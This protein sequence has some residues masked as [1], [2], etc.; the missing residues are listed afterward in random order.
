MNKFAAS[1]GL[2]AL[3]TTALHAVEATALNTMQQSKPW[4]VAAS[5]RGFYDDNINTSQV[6]V[7]SFGIEISPSVDFGLAGEQ[8]SFNL[9]YQLSARWYDTAPFGGED[10]WD[11]THIFD[12]ALTHTFSP[13]VDM[14]IQNSF[15]IGQEPDILRDS[16][17]NQRIDGNNL[18]NFGSI[19]FNIEVTELMGL[20]VGYRNSYFNY[21][22]PSNAALL[23]R[24]ENRFTIDSRW[25]LQPK[26][27]GIV[28]YTYGQTLYTGDAPIGVGIM[29]D[30]R[31]VRSH[32]MYVGA[33][34]SFTPTLSGVLKAGAE[35]LDYYGNPNGDNQWSPYVEGTVRY[36]YRST[37]SMD[38]GF[39]YSHSAAD[40]AGCSAAVAASARSTTLRTNWWIAPESRKRT[41]VF[42]GWTFTSTRRGSM[43]SHS[44]NAGWRS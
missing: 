11:L 33:E 14:R 36:Q 12:G 10:N 22:D 25:K 2:V 39:Q 34:H 30:Y 31:N 23:N 17:S 40:T 5:L 19:F 43:S 29:S 38:L 6:E 16:A 8:T 27:T 44:A 24:I 42:C 21:D 13:R 35:F 37:T 26:T 32:R 4:S 9:G 7:D 28:G 18:V 3:G 15:A 20:S 41:S 1:L